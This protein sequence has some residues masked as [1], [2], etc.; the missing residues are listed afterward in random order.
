MMMERDIDESND[1]IVYDSP[2]ITRTMRK[3]YAPTTDTSPAPSPPVSR[4]RKSTG[5][6]SGLVTPR[7]LQREQSVIEKR[8]RVWIEESLG[9]KF[10]ER[11][12]ADTSAIPESSMK[13]S[14]EESRA[15]YYNLES[16]VILCKLLERYYP[17]TIDVSK[18]HEFPNR[19]YFI[20]EDREKIKQT[21]YVAL[22]KSNVKLFLDGVRRIDGFPVLAFF[23]FEDLFLQQNKQAILGCLSNLH[24]FATKP[25]EEL[26]EEEEEQTSPEEDLLAEEE[27]ARLTGGVA[28]RPILDHSSLIRRELTQTAEFAQASPT[29]KEALVKEVVRQ[30][31]SLSPK[32]LSKPLE[33]ESFSKVVINVFSLPF[34]ILFVLAVTIWRLYI[35]HSGKTY[36]QPRFV[37]R[38]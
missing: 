20:N 10:E 3:S 16:G 18:V 23:S 21:N 14:K 17:S 25:V 26:E 31:S 6:E 2:S 29:T 9:I 13:L 19:M 1:A 34:V 30:S 22:A 4:G 28:N 27:I 5:S 32:T 15:F 35:E 36:E 24:L 33:K 8:L 11:K 12:T 37:S 7:R 38:Q